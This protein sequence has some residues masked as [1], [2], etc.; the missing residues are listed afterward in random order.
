MKLL[1]NNP[2]KLASE[3]RQKVPD[4]YRKIDAEDI[5]YMTEYGLVGRYG[6]Y[7]RDD[8]KTV[9][10]ILKCE[11]RRQNREIRSE[12][13]GTNGDIHCCLCDAILPV[14]PV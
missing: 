13:K 3:F 8:L 12:I 10:G 5:R 14:Q 6:F 11:Q 4:A 7:L 9:W 2:N 1:T